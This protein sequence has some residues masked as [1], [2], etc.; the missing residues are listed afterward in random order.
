MASDNKPKKHF[1]FTLIN[2]L[3]CFFS[4]L[5]DW[6]SIHHRLINVHHYISH[7]KSKANDHDLH[8]KLA[9]EIN[10]KSDGAGENFPA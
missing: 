7:A 5:L 3:L 4:R 6:N 1:S 2:P 10:D 8:P 9:A